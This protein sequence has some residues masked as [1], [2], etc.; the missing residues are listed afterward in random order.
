LPGAAGGGE[1]GGASEEGFGRRSGQ[2]LG[3]RCDSSGEVLE[4]EAREDDSDHER[5]ETQPGGER[6]QA[7]EEGIGARLRAHADEKRDQV[8][9][10]LA[11]NAER[12]IMSELFAPEKPPKTA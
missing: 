1:K 3:V 6:E 11:D 8:V 5:G 4:L 9:V 10:L 7:G 2:T 12:Y